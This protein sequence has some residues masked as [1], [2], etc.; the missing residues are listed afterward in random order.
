MFTIK[1]GNWFHT[2][3][4]LQTNELMM[5][6]SEQWEWQQDE[7]MNMLIYEIKTDLTNSSNG[8]K[9]WKCSNLQSKVPD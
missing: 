8:S 7:W 9:S 5:N 3:E 6:G 2:K 1:A 4:N